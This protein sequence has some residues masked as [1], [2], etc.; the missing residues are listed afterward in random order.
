M[1][2]ISNNSNKITNMKHA[3]L[4]LCSYGIDYLNN[5]VEQF[6]NDKRFDIFIHLDG[7]SKID[8]DN[9]IEIIPSNIKYIGHLY[10]SKRYSF[11]MV[12]AMYELLSIA[13]KTDKYDYFHFF[14]ETC[15]MVKSLDDFNQFFI[16]NNFKSYLRYIRSNK[17]FHK[18]YSNIFYMGSQ[19]MSL[20][21]NIARKLINKTYIYNYIKKE[22]KSGIIKKNINYGAP[23][24]SIL[25]NIIISYICDG[26]TKKCRI[27]NNNLRCIKFLKGRSHPEFLNIDDLSKKEI[28]FIKSNC[29]II[30]KINYKNLKAI[31]LIKVLKELYI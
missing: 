29:L 6:H 19:W 1:D 28:N 30:R 12:D 15:Y 13:Y 17:V 7:K 20:H 5:F 26:N 27:I 21:N 25:H 24:E 11:E 8:F 9:N 2:N 31:E 10:K 4:L 18:K 22:V 3:I 14:S 23:D 16:N